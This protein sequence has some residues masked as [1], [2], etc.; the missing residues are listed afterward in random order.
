MSATLWL[1]TE[2]EETLELGGTLQ[3]Y[4]A[5]ADMAHA[6]GKT[7]YD[8]YPDLFGVVSQVEDQADADPQWLEKVR[9]Q[10]KVFEAKYSP[11]LKEHTLWILDQLSPPRV[12]EALEESLT[13]H[14]VNVHLRTQAK[15]RQ[16]QAQAKAE[17]AGIKVNDATGGLLDQLAEIFSHPAGAHSKAINLFR[18]L[19]QSAKD[20]MAA[21]LEDLA[22]WAWQHSAD[23]L[24]RNLPLDYLRV[25]AAKTPARESLITE[26]VTQPLV[27]GLAHLIYRPGAGLAT[28]DPAA[29]LREPVSPTL[30]E[31]EQR[32]LFEEL[33]FPAPTIDQILGV[34]NAPGYAGTWE[35]QLS[36]A[37]S[38]ASP[39]VL[40]DILTRGLAGGLTREQIVQ[41]ILPA[42]DGFRNSAERIART[43]GLR[44]AHAMNMRA[45]DVIDD[46]VVGYQIHATPSPVP[47][48]RAWHQKRSGTI[49]YKE[50]AAGQKGLQQ[51]P[52]P[53]EEAPDASER[54]AGTPQTAYN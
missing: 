15:A 5:F 30:S 31:E 51:M 47:P 50:P 3:L 23:Y 44:I 32:R 18:R 27:P 10:A 34:M 24:V 38:L 53:P 40:A 11:H 26:D 54:P 43:E 41:E 37:T 22:R 7:C 25:A 28:T 4:E 6:A 42:V 2:R 33:L 14:P 29:P 35:E 39:E 20:A 9:Q 46:L 19:Q 45:N 48:S 8:D 17:D 36:R 12:A 13:Q 1:N 16:E 52:S 49:Y 21:A